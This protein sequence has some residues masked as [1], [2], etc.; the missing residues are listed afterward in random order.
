MNRHAIVIGAG[1]AG[2]SA[3]ERLAARGWQITLVERRSTPGCGASG[4]LAGVL[5]PLPSVD[6]NRLAR[7]T[8]SGFRMPARIL[9]RSPRP[10]CRCA[11]SR[12][13]CCISRA[14]SGTPRRSSAWSRCRAGGERLF[15]RRPR[16]RRANS[17]AGRSPTA[18]GGFPAAAGS[19]RHRSAGPIS[20]ATRR[21]PCALRLPW[22]R[23]ST[24]AGLWRACDAA[25]EVIAEAPILILANASDARRFAAATHLPLRAARGQVSHL[26]ARA[27]SAPGVVV[28]RLGYVTPAI[29]G[30]RCAGATF[31]VDDDDAGLRD[32]DH[33]ENLDRLDFILPGYRQGIDPATLGGRVGFRPLSPDR[34]PMIGA[35]ADA[36]TP[37]AKAFPLPRR[38]A[39]PAGSLPRE[40]FWRPRHRLVG[41]RRRTGRLPDQR[42]AIA[43]RR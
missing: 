33:A 15:F 25:G 3:A 11:G 39:A 26:P 18:A 27:S 31:A 41:A 14:T 13:A 34:L 35:V 23:S 6:D 24:L 29:D 22:R 28:C 7:L 36:A 21:D 30:L 42:R 40:R 37:T 19:I 32:A 2:S 1:L 10:A 16:N 12:P 20:C 38:N 43:A 17:L 4:N 5:R 9:R 8:R